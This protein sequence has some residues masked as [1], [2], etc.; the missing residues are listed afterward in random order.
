MLSHDGCV[1]GV[2]VILCFLLILF[3]RF[4]ALPFLQMCQREV[5]VNVDAAVDLCYFVM[6]F[7]TVVKQQLPCMSTFLNL[8]REIRARE[9]NW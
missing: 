4:V 2:C 1:C 5:D 8:H 9:L 7:N 6:S 3:L